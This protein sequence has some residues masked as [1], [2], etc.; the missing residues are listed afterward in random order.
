MGLCRDYF[1]FILSILRSF[2]MLFLVK[3]NTGTGNALKVYKKWWN[4]GREME[5]TVTYIKL[6]YF[7]YLLSYLVR[8][9]CF[10]TTFSYFAFP[11]SGERQ[12]NVCSSYFWINFYLRKINNKTKRSS[13]S[14]K[15]STGAYGL[16]L[17]GPD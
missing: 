15:G 3:T 1:T 2:S 5:K 7:V 8:W 11:H 14:R 12:R 17:S 4:E 16:F 10:M 9:K 6:S 13:W